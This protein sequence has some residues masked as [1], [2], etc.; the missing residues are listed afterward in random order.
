MRYIF[1]KKEEKRLVFSLLLTERKNR[2]H[3]T[4]KKNIAERYIGA[5]RTLIVI[6]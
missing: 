3:L 1:I 6:N 5:L 2:L 4:K